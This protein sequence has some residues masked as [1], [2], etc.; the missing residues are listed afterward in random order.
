LYNFPL[1]SKNMT[2]L[3]ASFVCPVKSPIMRYNYEEM[4]AATRDFSEEYMIG[5]GGFG[6]VYRANIRLTAVAVKRLHQ[7]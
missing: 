4:R 5:R 6:D 3:N 1:F 7:V 2:D